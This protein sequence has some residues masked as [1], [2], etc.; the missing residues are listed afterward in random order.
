MDDNIWEYPFGD[1]DEDD[2]MFFRLP[3]NKN[4]IM[5]A[6]PKRVYHSSL[7][8]DRPRLNRHAVQVAFGVRIS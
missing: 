8:F 2:D 6:G 1:L 4:V 5:P 3:E 7:D